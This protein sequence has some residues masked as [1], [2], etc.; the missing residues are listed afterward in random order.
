MLE[1]CRVLYVE[2]DEMI[3]Q[4]VARK[5]RRHVGELVEAENGQAGLHLFLESPYDLVIVDMEMPVMDGL[6][7]TRAILQEKPVT[8]IVMTTAHNE[9]ECL[10]AAID[11]G[12]T[13]VVHKPIDLAGLMETLR[14]CVSDS[15]AEQA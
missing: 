3:R 7:L 8:P 13:H 4:L 2:D 1:A 15:G 9:E 6:V 10:K 14:L 12:V 11:A 5:V